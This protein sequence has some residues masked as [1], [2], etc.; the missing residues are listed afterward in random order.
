MDT[1]SNLMWEMS[2]VLTLLIAIRFPTFLSP[3][4]LLAYH[5]VFLLCKH[6]LGFRSVP[7][8][9]VPLIRRHY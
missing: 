6:N 3:P 9:Q 8:R 4:T 1:L 5:T 7:L 2:V